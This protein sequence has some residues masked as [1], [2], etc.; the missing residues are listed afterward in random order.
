MTAVSTLLE[1]RSRLFGLTVTGNFLLTVPLRQSS[2]AVDLVLSLTEHPLL[3]PGRQPSLP[4][5]ASPLR[6]PDGASLGSLYSEP[7]GALYHFPG[8][9]DFRVR[10]DRIE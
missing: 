6:R 9:G 2:D 4:L 3:D 10:P 1:R 7:E 5:Y 8:A